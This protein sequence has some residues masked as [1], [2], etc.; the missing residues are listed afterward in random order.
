LVGFGGAAG[1]V[2]VAAAGPLGSGLTSS[3]TT[4]STTGASSLTS[5]LAVLVA[6]FFAVFFAAGASTGAAGASGNSARS[7]R[8]TGASIDD[9]APFTNSPISASLAITTLLST[10]RSFAIS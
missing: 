1:G 2:K 5:V 7:L 9:D 10:P 6:A 4:G 8:A 3:F